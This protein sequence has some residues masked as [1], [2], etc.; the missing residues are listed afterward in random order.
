MHLWTVT[1]PKCW[2]VAKEDPKWKAAMH[3]ELRALDKNRTWEIVPLPPGKKAVGCKWVFTVKQTPEGKIDRYKE[4][5]V[6][7]GYSQ[8]YG[9]DY[10]ETY[11][12]FRF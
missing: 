2:Q 3:E 6:A 7:K 9:I 8:T 11:G 5:L 1:L 4:R 12:I 10:D